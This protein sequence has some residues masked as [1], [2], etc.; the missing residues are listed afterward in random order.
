MEDQRARSK[1][2]SKISTEIFSSSGLDKIPADIT[3]TVFLGYEA[4]ES[5]AR[6]L[7]HQTEGAK[8]TVILDRTPFYAESGGQAGDQGILSGEGLKLRVLDTHKLDK[9]FLHLVEIMEGAIV[10]GKT[11]HAAVDRQLREGIMRNHTATHLLHAV[12]RQTLGNSVRQLGSMVAAE[13]FRFDYSFGRALTT[14]ELRSIE[15]SVNE[16]ILANYTVRKQVQ[17]LEKAKKDGALAFFGDKYGD[18]VRMVTIEQIS[19]E[20]CGGT[21]CDATGQIGLFLI[22]A[23]TS[24]ASG[25]RRIEAVTG[26][27][28]LRYARSVQDQLSKVADTLKVGVADISSRAEKLMENLKKQ[29]AQS[30]PAAVTESE[31]QRLIAAAPK[32]GMCAVLLHE[33]QG[34]DVNALRTLSDMLRNSGGK[35]IYVIAA[36]SDGKLNVIGGA[37]KDLSKSSF[38]MKDLFGRLSELLGVSGGGRRDF[39]QGGGRDQGQFAKSTGQMEAIIGDYLAEKGI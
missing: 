23:E 34:T 36:S 33:M 25:V 6:I 30:G 14:G 38:D 12:L 11:V 2:S 20:L 26:L 15:N 32:K 22:T 28:A 5:D 31:V 24:V 8:A 13:R 7:W 1:E 18:E 35:L 19:K 21:H 17:S 16:Q 9:Y 37:S 4:L 29:K 3:A 27:G 10:D 39:V